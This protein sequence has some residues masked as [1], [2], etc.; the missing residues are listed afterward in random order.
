MVTGGNHAK[1]VFG[2][3]NINI[4]QVIVNCLRKIWRV[5]RLGM[6][7]IMESKN[8]GGGRLKRLTPGGTFHPPLSS[9]SNRC[10]L[11]YRWCI[12]QM[13]TSASLVHWCAIGASN[14]CTLVP[15]PHTGRCI[16][17]AKRRGRGREGRGLGIYTADFRD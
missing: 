16:A 8:G 12:Q 3:C 2:I 17:E 14:R 7:I 9:V 11:V 5:I 15:P 6:R 13:Y 1:L 4:R 10:I